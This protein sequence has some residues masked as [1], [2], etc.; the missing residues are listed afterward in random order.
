MSI[1]LHHKDPEEISRKR[2]EM[3]KVDGKYFIELDE[4]QGLDSIVELSISLSSENDVLRERVSILE[5]KIRDL[6]NN[7]D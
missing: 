7:I 5:E 2:V 1:Y 3:I 4:Y 6:E